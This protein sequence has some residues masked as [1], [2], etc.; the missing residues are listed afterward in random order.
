MALASRND[1]SYHEQISSTSICSNTRI[2]YLV[3][4]HARTGAF[5]SVFANSCFIV[6]SNFVLKL[7][8]HVVHYGPDGCAGIGFLEH[9]ILAQTDT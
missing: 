7:D 9:P 2:I 3:T 5:Q 1:A 6:V 8:Y 4:W